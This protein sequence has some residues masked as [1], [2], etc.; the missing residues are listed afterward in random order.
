MPRCLPPG[1]E[2]KSEPLPCALCICQFTKSRGSPSLT[3]GLRT[4]RVTSS[5]QQILSLPV[6]KPDHSQQQR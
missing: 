5:K 2:S 6:W 3:M 1:V 4:W